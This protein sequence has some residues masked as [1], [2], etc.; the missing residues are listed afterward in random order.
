MELTITYV[1]YAPPELYEQVPFKIRLLRII[2]STGRSDYWMAQMVD[3]LLWVNGQERLQIDH[4]VVWARWRGT[5]IV[6]FVRDL[7]IGIAYV[8]DPTQITA[9]RLDVNKC[10]YVAIALAN[11]TSGD[12]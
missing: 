4:V 10:R 11:D 9:A 2:P 3:P 12:P 7:P 8:T 5:Q 1:D 6:P